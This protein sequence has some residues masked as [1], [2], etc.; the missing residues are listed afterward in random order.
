MNMDCLYF[1]L[2][3]WDMKMNTMLYDKPTFSGNGNWEF[4]DM[5]IYHS[6][7]QLWYVIAMV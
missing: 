7:V 5:Y 2:S 1:A 6:F 3:K 4:T